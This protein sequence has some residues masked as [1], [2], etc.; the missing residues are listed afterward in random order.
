MLA[1]A[2]T[3]RTV[4][5][6]P[7]DAFTIDSLVRNI[8]TKKADATFTVTVFLSDDNVVTAADTDFAHYDLDGLNAGATNTTHVSLVAPALAGTY[9]LAVDADSAGTITESSEANNF[10]SVITLI[11]GDANLTATFGEAFT[12][13]S[14]VVPGDRLRVPVVVK[15]E[16]MLVA[17]GVIT[18][19][20]TASANALPDGGDTVLGTLAGRRINL[21]PGATITLTFNVT[22]T[23][24]LALGNWHLLAN[25]DTTDAIAE[26]SEADNFAATAG[27]FE[28]A[29]QF[30]A[31]PAR[32]AARLTLDDA[33]TLVTFSSRGAGYGMVTAGV[34][35]YDVTMIGSD[36]STSVSIATRGGEADLGDVTIPGSI[37]G[38]GQ[39]GVAWPARRR[40]GRRPYHAERHR[41]RR[42]RPAHR[43]CRSH[44]PRHPGGAVAGQRGGRRRGY[45]RFGRPLAGRLPMAGR[46][47]GRPDRPVARQAHRRRAGASGDFQPT[48][49]LSG[50]I[51]NASISG[52]V[53][54]A[55]TVL[56]L[57]SMKA[58][59]LDGLVMNLTQTV[60]PSLKALGSLTVSGWM[61]D[62]RILSAGNIGKVSVAAVSALGYLRLGRAASARPAGREH[63][64]RGP[65]ARADRLGDGDR[66]GE[67]PRRALAD[68]QR[69]RRLEPGQH[70]AHQRAAR[71]RAAGRL[72]PVGPL[73][74]P[75]QLSRARA[76]LQLGS[77]CRR[78]ADAAGRRFRRLPGV[79]NIPDGASLDGSGGCGK[80][81]AA[82]AAPAAT[83]RG[84]NPARGP[85]KTDPRGDHRI[86]EQGAS[87][88]QDS[89]V[90][91]LTRKTS[92]GRT[93]ALRR[94]HRVPAR[95]IGD[96]A[97]DVGCVLVEWPAFRAVAGGLLSHRLG[98]VHA[99]LDAAQTKGA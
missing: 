38:F 52:S 12:L 80:D 85:E 83:R 70:Q 33:G 34:S 61:T 29:W 55:W 84:H 53:S 32:S 86:H 19:E 99:G 30:G 66:A 13:P 41:R 26:S 59:E 39:G 35:G 7:G 78:R 31:I 17:S 91:V 22:V 69:H 1:T 97:G 10:G 20:L 96:A 14:L 18:S 88:C 44:Q 81:R 62:S 6:H 21:A 8:G 50:A 92:S 24:A 65:A 68:R 46:G 77:G 93:S 72:G 5:V 40:R 9:Y 49:T 23:D 11:V 37:G 76:E 54:G 75:L 4:T 58:G 98:A 47:G 16:G 36:A 56:S 64:V 25:V 28:Q 79:S 57:G 95:L 67:G 87:A 73:A 94:T 42:D 2:A 51:G 90:L 43:R 27:T 71:Q 48:V 82:T 60:D 3:A 89:R 63:R 74:R 45:R 15:N